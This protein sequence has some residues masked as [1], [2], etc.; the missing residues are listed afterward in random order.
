MIIYD[1]RLKML[2]TQASTIKTTPI[3]IIR[4]IRINFCTEQSRSTLQRHILIRFNEL[5]LRLERSLAL[6]VTF[7]GQ[8]I[9]LPTIVD[10]PSLGRNN[11]TLLFANL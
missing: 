11:S 7:P 3:M 6:A 9:L 4:I 10:L 5:C 8:M 1:H 2:S